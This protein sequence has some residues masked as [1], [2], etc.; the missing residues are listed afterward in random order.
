MRHHEDRNREKDKQ[1]CKIHTMRAPVMFVIGAERVESTDARRMLAGLQCEWFL[2][3]RLNA[4]ATSANIASVNKM[5]DQ[6]DP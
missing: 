4:H 6:K 2:P 5:T 3:S 1:I